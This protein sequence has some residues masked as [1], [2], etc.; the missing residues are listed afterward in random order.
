MTAT[1]TT[2]EQLTLRAACLRVS[3]TLNSLGAPRP[4]RGAGG[5]GE[6]TEAQGGTVPP[7]TPPPAGAA[8]SHPR[9]H[10]ARVLLAVVVCF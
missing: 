1:A 8:G 5:R 3:M 4:E 10:L 6:E 2:T 7:P 9:E